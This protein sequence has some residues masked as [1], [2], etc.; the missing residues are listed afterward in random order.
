M[1]RTQA[2]GFGGQ[3]SAVTTPRKCACRK[4]EMIPKRVFLVSLYLGNL[5][6]LHL[7]QKLYVDL[8]TGSFVSQVL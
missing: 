7:L 6:T 5:T 2:L 8:K 4:T 1:L 3:V